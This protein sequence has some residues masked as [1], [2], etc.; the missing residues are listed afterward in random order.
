MPT[1]IKVSDQ[2]KLYKL[3]VNVSGHFQLDSSREERAIS[4]VQDSLAKN[5][6]NENIANIRSNILSIENSDLFSVATVPED[7]LKQLEY[8]A[9]R[10]VKEMPH[11]SHRI[12]V[13]E[14]PALSSQI[15]GSVPMWANGAAIEKSIGPFTR[16]DGRKIWFDFYEIQKL[17][18]LYIEGEFSPAVLFSVTT[19]KQL[20]SDTPDLVPNPSQVYELKPSSIWINSKIFSSNAP[21]G[22]YTGLKIRDGELTLSS[23]PQIINGKLTI[24]PATVV[25][26]KLILE[27]GKDESDNTSDY[28][29][30]SRNTKLDLPKTLAFHFSGSENKID[31]ITNSVKWISYGHKANFEWNSQELP[32]YDETL[33]R[34]LIPLNCSKNIFKIKECQSPFNNFHGKATIQLSA[35][36]LPVANIDISRPLPAK[37]I[38][39]V[40]I[41][42]KRGLSMK[43]VGLKGDEINLQNP[44]VLCDVG[45]NII[46]DLHAGNLYCSQEF[47][48][49]KDEMNKFGSSIKL[50]YTTSFPLVYI[51]SAD[52]NESLIASVSSN[53]L[54]DRPVTV[55]GNPLDIHSENSTLVLSLHKI[56]KLIYLYD[57]NIL[58]D[59]YDPST[60]KGTISPAISLALHN[61]LFKL[62]SVNGC[63]LFGNL[64][65]DLTKIE[66]GKLFLVFGLYAYLP[67]LPD[68]YA[69]NLGRMKYQFRRDPNFLPTANDAQ[70]I[71]SWF[72][73]QTK[74]K[75][76]LADRDD[77]KLSF[78]FARMQDLGKLVTSSS[79]IRHR[80]TDLDDFT[81]LFK[82]AHNEVEGSNPTA[83]GFLNDMSGEEMKTLAAIV[84]NPPLPDYQKIWDENF[85]VFQNDLFALLDVSSNANQLGVSFGSFGNRPL[86]MIRTHKVQ[87]D[88][89]ITSENNQL[90]LRIK[91]MDVTARGTFVRAF[92]VPQISWEP[93]IN[94]IDLPI[95]PGDPPKPFNY[96]PDDGGPTK[97]M[98]N[99]VKFV[100][101]TP[102]EMSEFLISEYAIEPDN[103][104]LAYLTLPFGMRSLAYLYK[105]DQD[106]TQKPSIK[107]NTPNFLHLQGG[108]QFRLDG[109]SGFNDQQSN[110]FRGHTLQI[111]NVLDINGVNTD[112]S[113]LGHDV[114]MI[115]NNEFFDIG[116][117]RGVPLTRID[118]SGYGSSIFSNWIN[119]N[120]QFAS[121]SQAKFD[122]FVGR[123]AHEI[124]QVKSILYPWGVKV[125]RTITLFR[126]GSGYVYRYDSGWK[127][128]SDGNFD[129]R[130][131]WTTSPKPDEEEANL[132]LP[133][134][135][136]PGVIKG[137]SNIRNIRSAKNDIKPFTTKMNLNGFYQVGPFDRIIEDN[138][139]D[140][141]DANLEPVYFDADI[142]IENVIQGQIKGL[143]PSK[144]IL[145][146]VQLAPRGIPLTPKA[147]EELL[148]YQGGSIG[149]PLNCI[150]DIGKSGQKMRLNC[151]D[152]SNSTDDSKPADPQLFVG[153]A[154]GNVILPKDGSWSLVTHKQG[155]G[156]VTPLPE[157]QTVPLIRIGEMAKED[158]S[159]PDNGLL[160]IANPTELL[161]TPNDSTTNFGFLQSTNTQKV[162]FLTPAFEK[163][164]SDTIPGKLLSKTPPL[165]ADAFRLIPSKSIFPNIHDDIGG[166]GDAIALTKD[167]G[168]SPLMDGG[169]KVLELMNI[170]TAD[171]TNKVKE[172]GYKLINNAKNFDLPNKEWFLINEAYLKLY[173]EYKAQTQNQDESKKVRDGSLDYDV[174]SYA[175]GWKSR[176]NNLSMAIDLGPITRI[177]IIKG[178]F[179]AK[180]GSNASFIGVEGDPDFPSPQLEFGPDL[181]PIVDILQILQRLQG[182]DY[183]AAIKKGLEIAMSNSAESWEY[184][185]EASKEIPVVK[186]P[187]PVYD[188]P[189]APLRLEASLKVGVYF[190]AALTTAALTD[191]NKLLPTAGAFL[192][193]YGRL[194]VMCAS[195]GGA[196]IYA[197]GQVNLRVAADTRLGPSLDMKFGVGAQIVVGLPVVGNVS[198][199]YMTGVEIYL[200][201]EKVNISAFMLFQGHA[202]LLGG[203]VGITITIEAK[204]T[205]SR[206]ELPPPNKDKSHTDLMA[207]ITFALDISIFLVIDISFSESWEEKRQIA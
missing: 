4:S 71:R 7:Q 50:Q 198:V 201:S 72:I 176:L 98:N 178:N 140:T 77:V 139:N 18:A 174:N 120:A 14:V 138:K 166:F 76:Q 143:V 157:S 27:V 148:A 39:G 74:W 167:F 126:V 38:G 158:L 183:A 121:T 89:R 193:F 78:H 36:A 172:D 205:V 119:K 94:M 41:K 59:N 114:S 116:N 177:M 97:I 75:S 3:L 82:Q 142:E 141:Q 83:K 105:M 160:R 34:V 99:S 10:S 95:V 179:D 206:T 21:D 156:D 180:K 200:D 197:V 109:G 175:V 159:F 207:Q 30:D 5:L 154:R 152:V 11:V 118:L 91:E 55:S 133:Y 24:S 122:V 53:P 45:K 90:P 79:P 52:G 100:P 87:S 169:K 110:M 29:I 145:G 202:E 112:A 40:V 70:R 33:N 6:Q 12:F 106:Q 199:L 144:K 191:A 146:F 17:A 104:T 151:F 149:G 204:G 163:Q 124:I 13:R 47:G 16:K 186:F 69:A 128:E 92:T 81:K 189:A 123:T 25:T 203:V 115:F 135:I 182:A 64:N 134:A 153:A 88:N 68:P 162:L 184:K 42:C 190:N 185:F 113:T 187:P 73:C 137:L 101:I 130:F 108:I 1:E 2:E 93:V 168:Q 125:V 80:E 107:F 129:F 32:T 161:R 56:F 8:L 170:N 195:V 84:E 37:S 23:Q 61:A 173:V 147:F 49:W 58:F 22:C 19:S 60:Q 136:H 127:P 51:T 181:K 15:K 66:N 132:E 43:W 26:V 188:S 85:S 65:P 165:F 63:L 44:Y 67:T 111:N 96:Y 117:N 62:T 48:L 131:K 192:E 57:D 86:A 171:G 103:I 20:T 150:I 9:D 31:E 164:I 54:L 28:G 194:S 155:T 35:W 102:I 196:T 46:T